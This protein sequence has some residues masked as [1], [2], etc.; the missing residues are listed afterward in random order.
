MRDVIYMTAIYEFHNLT[1]HDLYM[2]ME[3][4]FKQDVLVTDSQKT[5]RM[6]LYAKRK[7]DILLENNKETYLC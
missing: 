5:V 4:Q 7:H 6:R 3:S 1:A 2:K